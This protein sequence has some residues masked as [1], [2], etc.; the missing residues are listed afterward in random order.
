M[1]AYLI[2]KIIIVGIVILGV[3]YS[4]AS[5]TVDQFTPLFSSGPLSGYVTPEMQWGHDVILFALKYVLI[6]ALIGLMY[7]TYQ[8]GQKPEQPWR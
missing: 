8:M 5:D 4:F 7:F 2:F 3:F 1:A 6:P